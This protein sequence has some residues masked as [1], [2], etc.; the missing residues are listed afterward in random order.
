MVEIQLQANAI[1]HCSDRRCDESISVPVVVTVEREIEVD[2]V[3]SGPIPVSC[4]DDFEIPEDWQCEW[5]DKY[6]CPKHGGKR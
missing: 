1:I 6:Y 5:G 3:P 4:V 2:S